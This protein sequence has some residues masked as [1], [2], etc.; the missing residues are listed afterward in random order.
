MLPELKDSRVIDL[1]SKVT[2]IK[3]TVAQLLDTMV[4]EKTNLVDRHNA[5]AAISKEMNQLNVTGKNWVKQHIPEFML[6]AD[7][8]ALETI[9]IYAYPQV[10]EESSSKIQDQFQKHML[11]ATRSISSQALMLLRFSNH[12]PP[13]EKERGSV[14]IVGKHVKA[15]TYALDFYVAMVAKS[16][17]RTARRLATI[18]RAKLHGHTTFKISNEKTGS[19][20]DNYAGKIYT[21]KGLQSLPNQGPPFH[22]FCN[23]TIS[24][25]MKEARDER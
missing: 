5:A 6:E 23:H 20:C 3:W 25:H 21:L 15:R 14:R 7:K 9:G 12:F 4:L 19:S 24:I 11:R 8:E 10:H 1:V 18:E 16:A 2:E 17:E 13:A 22:P